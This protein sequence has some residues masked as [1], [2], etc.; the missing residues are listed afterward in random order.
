MVQTTLWY[1]F[2]FEPVNSKFTVGAEFCVS[3]KV[4][5]PYLNC[6]FWLLDSET[7]I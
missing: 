2:V 3:L 5:Y 4:S 1:L 7:W 6:A